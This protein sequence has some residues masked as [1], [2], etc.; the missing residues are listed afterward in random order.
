MVTTAG[1]TPVNFGVM[2]GTGA[3]MRA[4]P[5][6]THS[7]MSVILAGE[8]TARSVTSFPASPRVSGVGV[9]VFLQVD[10][11]APASSAIAGALRWGASPSYLQ[12]DAELACTD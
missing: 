11:S 1:T 3:R 7:G 2:V 6:L 4:V 12:F 8:G 5:T 10:G 9:F